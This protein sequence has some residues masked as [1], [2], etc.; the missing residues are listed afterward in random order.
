M[1]LD[2]QVVSWFRFFLTGLIKILCGFNPY[3]QKVVLNWAYVAFLWDLLSSKNALLHQIYVF[4]IN[5]YTPVV[6]SLFTRL[7]WA[8]SENTNVVFLAEGSVFWVVIVAEF[9]L[10]WIH[11][12][13]CT[14]FQIPILS[15]HVTLIMIE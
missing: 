7:N 6:Q 11:I 2:L 12:S 1:R 13:V 15:E 8:N 10:S 5:R 4:I 14:Y 9:N 3:I